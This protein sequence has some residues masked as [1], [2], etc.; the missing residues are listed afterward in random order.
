VVPGLRGPG[1]TW[2]WVYVVPG[3][4]GPGSR[5]R[6]HVD[7]AAQQSSGLQGLLDDVEEVWRRPLEVKVLGDASGEVLEALRGGA[8][9]QGLIAAVDSEGHRGLQGGP[10]RRSHTGGTTQEE[11]HRRSHTG[12]ATQEG[13]HR[14]SHTGG[15]TQ[16]EPHRRGHI[17]GATQEGPHRTPLYA[18]NTL[19]FS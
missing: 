11:P 9:R 12:G 4:R 7:G 14:R 10:H 16:E 13:P 5:W 15:A 3:L 17:G 19:L 18:D 2:S 8:S 1:F 6:T